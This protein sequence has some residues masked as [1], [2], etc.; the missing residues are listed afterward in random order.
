VSNF[1]YPTEGW[2]LTSDGVNLIMSD[3]SNRLYFLDPDTHERISEIQVRD[4]NNN[5]ISNLNELEYI[6]G[7]VY[8][9]I[10]E[11]QV[12]AIINPQTGQVSAW[13]N[14]TNLNDP[15]GVPTESLMMQEMTDSS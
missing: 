1:T 14:L 4:V 5:S 8:A 9:N 13:I 2:G 7:M 15:A 10:F 6:K 3:G 11:Q 12:I